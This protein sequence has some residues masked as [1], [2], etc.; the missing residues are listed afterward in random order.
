MYEVL[1][2]RVVGHKPGDRINLPPDVARR[3][4]RAGLIR[5][6]PPVKKAAAKK[7]PPTIANDVGD[8]VDVSTLDGGDD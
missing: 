6:V 7:A 1:S 3:K 8:P 4:V 2:R 5:K